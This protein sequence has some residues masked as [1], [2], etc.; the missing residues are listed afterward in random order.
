MDHLHRGDGPTMAL[1]EALAMRG[2]SH[3]LASS[4]DKNQCWFKHSSRSLPLHDAITALSVGFP[5]LL[6]SS[7]TPLKE[8]HRSKLSRLLV[9]TTV[10]SRN[11][12]PSTS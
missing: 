12:C 9:S 10:S 6:P 3:A 5:A 1:T 7:F 2:V 11:R 8:A 4:S